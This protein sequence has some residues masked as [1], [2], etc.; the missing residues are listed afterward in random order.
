PY[1]DRWILDMVKVLEQCMPPTNLGA[2][3]GSTTADLTWTGTSTNGWEVEVLEGTNVPGTGSPTHTGND[4]PFQV[5]GLTDSTPHTYYV[6]KNCGDSYSPWVGPFTFTTTQIPVNIE[7][8]GY[9]TDFE[10]PSHGWQFVN[11]T[12]ANQWVVGTAVSY[13]P[14]THLFYISNTGGSSNQYSNTA[15]SVVHVYRDVQI[16]A[17]ADEIYFS[18]DWRG[19]GDVNDHFKIWHTP[20]GSSYYLPTAGL[21]ILPIPSSG[22]QVGGNT[23]NHYNNPGWVNKGYTVQIPL[24]MQGTVRRFIIEW[25]NNN[26]GGVQPPAAIDN[27]NIHVI[28]CKAPTNPT[29][30]NTTTA[31][32]DFA[33]TAPA[34]VPAS[35]DYYITTEVGTPNNATVPTGNVGTANV[36]VDDLDPSTS[37]YFWVRSNCGDDGVSFWVGPIAFTTAPVVF[38]LANGND[39]ETGFD[40]GGNPG[41]TLSNGTQVN[42]WAVGTATSNSPSSSLYISNNNG[43]NNNYTIEAASIVHAYKDFAVPAGATEMFLSYDWKNSGQANTDYIRVWTVPASYTP[44]S[45]TLI[46]AGA[47]RQQFG[48]NHT[49]QTNW[50]PASYVINATAYAGSV[51][52]LVFEWRNDATGGTQPPGAIDNIN[53][54]VITCPAP[55][56]IT[57]G[58]ITDSS[59]ELS[60]TGTSPLY[61]YYYSTSPTNPTEATPFNGDTTDQN[62]NLTGLEE[63][64]VYYFWVRGNCGDLAGVS[65]WT[66]PFVFWTPQ[67]AIDLPYSQDYED[68]TTPTMMLFSGTQTNKWI[69]GTATSSSP[70]HSSY[71]S[72]D[73]TLNSYTGTNSTVHTYRTFMVPAGTTELGISYDWKGTGDNADVMN[74]WLVPTSF[75]PT[76][77]A[78]IT[79]ASGGTLLAGIQNNQPSWKNNVHVVDATVGIA[80]TARRLVFEW[81]NDTSVTNPPAAIDNI[82]IKVVTCPRPTAISASNITES[83]AILE[84]TEEGTATQWEYVVLPIGSPLP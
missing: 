67:I 28:T 14:G 42:K 50:T 64:T 37:Y 69:V 75:T 19:M 62:V 25:K 59:A 77:G 22:T 21:G 1:A 15:T 84:W 24:A 33:W 30:S 20:A 39:Y 48:G 43:A 82:V 13:C 81:R 60:W 12:Q 80:G 54:S 72:F 10:S 32:A 7:G 70:T 35:Y 63:G 4:V 57:A 3:A 11:G 65:F 16:P 34:V 78:Q 40:T 45:G 51:V 73:G 31:E 27:I 52:R 83:S 2:T 41:W 8:A 71:I 58:T 29:I 74:V 9:S 66:G 38:D 53:F 23:A 46:A 5:T 49:G 76:P 17:G 61:E 47:N 68:T 18:F 55:S 26:N 44:L 79:A 36:T 6:R 56:G